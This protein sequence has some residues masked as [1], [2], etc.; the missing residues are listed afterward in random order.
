MFQFLHGE[1]LSKENGVIKKV[2]QEILPELYNSVNI[3]LEVLKC[4]VQTVTFTGVRHIN[5][6][7][8]QKLPQESI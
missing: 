7:C 5:K 2:V 3:S 6:T 8:R 4:L 1:G